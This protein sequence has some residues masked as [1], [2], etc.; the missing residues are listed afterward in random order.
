MTVTNCTSVFQAGEQ[1]VKNVL[2]KLA[3]FRYRMQT[4][5]EMEP[6]ASGDDLKEWKSVFEIYQTKR[7]GNPRWT[8]VSWLFFEC[9]TYRKITELIRTE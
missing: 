4:D 9:Y 7:G 3:E 8:Q 1:A 6:I 5:K 2:S